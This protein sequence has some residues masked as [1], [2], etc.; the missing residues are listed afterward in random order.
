M[1]PQRKFMR[2]MHVYFYSFVPPSSGTRHV[3]VLA[4]A[5]QR[6]VLDLSVL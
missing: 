4:A 3:L 1:R 6:D 2:H 5:K